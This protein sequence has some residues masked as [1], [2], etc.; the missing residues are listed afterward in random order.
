MPCNLSTGRSE[1]C[2]D[3]QGGIKR[4]YLFKY[5]DYI[6]SQIVGVKGSTLTSFPPTD[7]YAYECVNATF[8]EQ[9]ENEDDGISINQTLN[10][11][12][13]QQDVET[14]LKLENLMKFDFRYIVEYNN[15]KFRIGGL[16]NGANIEE[17]NA[18]SGGSKAS[19]NGYKIIIKGDEEYPA[20]FIDD[21]ASVGFTTQQY[22]LLEDLTTLLLEDSEE[23]ELE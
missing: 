4:V 22:L 8:D 16:F 3:N 12:L 10:L 15:G 17:I 13:L 20:A 18:V 9:I 19:L 6:Y 7:I 2:L 5:V 23:L 14:T 11:T 1:P 21:L